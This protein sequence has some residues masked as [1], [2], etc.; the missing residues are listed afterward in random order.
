MFHHFLVNF[1]PKFM[2]LSIL[3]A[4]DTLQNFTKKHRKGK[5]YVN[6]PEFEVPNIFYFLN[7][8]KK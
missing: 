1:V 3:T 2:Y 7:F 6:F 4:Q 5:K 8:A